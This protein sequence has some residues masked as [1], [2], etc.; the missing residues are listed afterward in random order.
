[1]EKK[2][3]KYKKEAKLYEENE[4][5]REKKIKKKKKELSK[6]RKKECDNG[7]LYKLLNSDLLDESL[8]INLS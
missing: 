3:T 1:M 8:Y 4:K 7:S 6:K 2:V 5:K